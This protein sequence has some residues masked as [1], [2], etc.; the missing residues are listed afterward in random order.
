MPKII[1][2]VAPSGAVPPALLLR[3]KNHL[4]EKGMEARIPVNILGQDLTSSQQ[5]SVR[6][7]LL[8]QALFAEDSD[9]IWC[10][11]GG[12]GATRLLPRLQKLMPPAQSKMLIGFSDI[13]A[14]H[15]FLNQC[16][17]WQPIHGPT[18][19]QFVEEDP[20]IDQA[21]LNATQHIL[22][23][24][25]DFAPAELAKWQYSVQPLNSAAENFK[26]EACLTGGNLHLIEASLATFWQVEATGKILM[27]EE[28]NER[29]YQVDRAL[30]HLLQAG[31]FKQCQA[32]I[33]GDFTY[34][35][36]PAEEL[37][38]QAVIGRFI[39]ENNFP[40]FYAPFFGHGRQNFPWQ[41]KQA[42]LKNGVLLQ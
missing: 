34:P 6:F 27:L 2:I 30:I 10:I 8:Q 35:G 15:L 29:A 24:F 12:Y 3:I 37:A 38:I 39:R 14:L 32:V 23:H 41:Y 16:W 26:T 18:A 19:K 9:L 13:T 4:A 22:N 25:M 17:G 11:R 7:E 21:S 28:V 33:F 1:D 5:D 36:S 42:T 31:I 20:W 40:A